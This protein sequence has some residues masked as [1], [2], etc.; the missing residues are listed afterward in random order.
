[1]NLIAGLRR[2]LRCLT[3]ALRDGLAGDYPPVR[4]LDRIRGAEDLA[5][6]WKQR[7]RVVSEELRRRI[8]SPAVLRDLIP[9]RAAAARR[10]ASLPESRDRH[11]RFLEKSGAYRSAVAETATTHADVGAVEICGLNWSFPIR[12]ASRTNADRV[13][14]QGLP[15]RAIL[16]AREV[17][18]GGVTIDIGAN[19]GRTSIPRAVLGDAQVVYAAEPDPDNYRC[20]VRNVVTNGF[21]G[22]LI[23]EQLAVGSEDGDVRLVRSKYIG[24]H[25]IRSDVQGSRAESV[26]VPSHKLDTWIAELGV[27]LEQ[28]SFVK[29]DVQGWEVHVFEGAPAVLAAH[30]IAWQIEVDPPQLESAGS[31]LRELLAVIERHF[32]HVIDFNRSAEGNRA[33]EVASLGTRLGYLA[34]G[35]AHKTDVVLYHADRTRAGGSPP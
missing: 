34:D 25:A 15:L 27:A 2:R 20:L 1:V 10:R 24:G 30:H 31:S 14:E 33:V 35:R 23:P 19:I 12:P 28:V 26:R 32:T 3:L 16:Q 13:R 29:V 17:A 8:P 4:L 6:Q 11:E 21:A 5:Q 7:S 22:L 18:S 9:A